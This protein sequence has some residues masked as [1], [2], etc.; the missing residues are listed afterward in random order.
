MQP[1]MA[2]FVSPHGFGHAAR[3][4]AV[5]EAIQTLQPNLRFEIFTK[6]PEWFF[7]ESLPGPYG[8]HPLLTDIGLAQ[9]NS[10]EEDLPE[11]I[12]RLNKLLPYKHQL[13]ADLAGQ[14]R[15]LNG[16]L[17]LCDIAPMGIVAARAAGIPSVLIENFTWDWIYQGY[18]AYQAELKPHIT[19]LAEIFAAAD[20]H[21][22]TRPACQPQA[23]DLVTAPVSR[24][25]RQPPA[26]VRAALGVPAEAKMVLLTMGG[27]DWD[28]TFLNKLT[29]LDGVCVVTAG[30]SPQVESR[31]SLIYL[32]R[33]SNFYHPDLVNAGHAIIGKLGYSTL[34]EA[35]Q[36]NVPYG[37]IVRPQFR[38][39]PVMAGFV[40]TTMAGLEF[41]AAD[42]QN[43]AW[44]KKL[45]ELL[46]L[47]PARRAPAENGADQIAEFVVRLMNNTPQ[48]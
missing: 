32:S 11:S 47:P 34:A 21:I 2:Y 44:L 12:N 6:V 42:I 39:S 40:Q 19:Y 9:K 7:A 13:I 4:S 41:D 38:E 14:L 8:Y 26:R 1:T 45:P 37:Y 27:I 16:R 46:A 48:Q 5:M 18:P 24:K 36:A 33:H 43:G 30:H 17:V 20:Y 3:A 22:Q 23:V 25:L 31:G 28:Y 29:K 15:S 35:Y 10:L